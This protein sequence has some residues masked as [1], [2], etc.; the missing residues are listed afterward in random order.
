MKGFFICQENNSSKI[1]FSLSNLLF[2][3]AFGKLVQLILNRILQTFG[4]H[5]SI[6]EAVLLTLTNF[7]SIGSFPS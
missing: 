3:T 1:L 6:E 5:Q 7:H 4:L 2:I